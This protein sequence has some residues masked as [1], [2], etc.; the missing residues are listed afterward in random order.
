MTMNATFQGIFDALGRLSSCPGEN[1]RELLESCRRDLWDA[2]PEAATS[3][4]L[5]QNATQGWSQDAT[6]EAYLRAFDLA[7]LAVPYVSVHLFGE[8]NYRRGEFM[9]RLYEAYG[10]TG[11][12][13]GTELPDHFAV[14]LRYAD[15]LKGEERREL[16]ELCLREPLVKMTAT[17]RKN[18]HPYHF[19]LQALRDAVDSDLR[20]EVCHA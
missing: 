20:T 3:L 11:F 1:H 10:K 18:G 2:C 8:E 7:P 9:A 15:R 19:L 16:L 5:F 4:T 13:C 17:L 14:L 6:E 12:D